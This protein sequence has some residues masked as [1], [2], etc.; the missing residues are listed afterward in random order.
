[1]A[2]FYIAPHVLLHWQNVSISPVCASAE[3]IPEALCTISTGN[4]GAH[5]AEWTHLGGSHGA[6][7]KAPK[8]RVTWTWEVQ[9]AVGHLI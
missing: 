2:G 4:L 7:R 3:E 6:G 1:M 8:D 5:E 9:G